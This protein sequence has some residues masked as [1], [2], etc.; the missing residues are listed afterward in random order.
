LRRGNGSKAIKP[1]P[2][3]GKKTTRPAPDGEGAD[4]RFGKAPPKKEV[5]GIFGETKRHIVGR[6]GG[7]QQK[8]KDL[9]AALV[10][11]QSI[12]EKDSKAPDSSRKGEVRFH[13]PQS[14]KG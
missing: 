10:N 13:L 3:K 11:I 6:N 12:Q 7:N 14:K 4:S 1:P 9:E 5:P 8:K 2:I